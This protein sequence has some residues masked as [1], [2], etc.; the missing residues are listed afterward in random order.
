LWRAVVA[1]NLGINEITVQRYLQGAA[2]LL[3]RWQVD[4]R[5]LS[6]LSALAKARRTK[7]KLASAGET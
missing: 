7:L 4:K 2:S 1:S 5:E 3:E 6:R